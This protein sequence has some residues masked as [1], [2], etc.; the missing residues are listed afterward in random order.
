VLGRFA[1]VEREVAEDAVAAAVEAMEC[2]LRDGLAEAMNRF[3]RKSA[4]AGAEEGD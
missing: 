2:C 3:N 4:R 1:P